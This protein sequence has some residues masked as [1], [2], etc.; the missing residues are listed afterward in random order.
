MHK[1]D[2]KNVVFGVIFAIG[3]EQKTSCKS[4]RNCIQKSALCN[5]DLPPVFVTL[6]PSAHPLENNESQRG[7]AARDG[8]RHQ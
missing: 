3:F 6:H 7:G 2:I 8:C 1:N 5:S 4:E